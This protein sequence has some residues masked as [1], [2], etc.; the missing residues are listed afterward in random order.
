MSVC[1][2]VG[3]R[4]GQSYVSGDDYLKAQYD[5]EYKHT[6]RNFGIL[7]YFIIGFIVLKAIEADALVGELGAG[8]SVEQRKK[9]SIGVELVAKPDLLLFLDEPTSGLD[10]QSSWAIVQLLKKLANAGQSI[11]CTIHQPSATLFEQFDRL[12]LLKKGGQTVYFGDIGDNSSMVLDYFQR[13]GGRECDGSE[14]P[15]EYV[16][17]C[18]GAGATASVSENWHEIWKRSSEHEAV[19]STIQRLIQSSGSS[20][21]L[22]GDS[23]IEKYATDY[24]YQFKYVYLRT[25]VTFWRDLDYIMSKMMLL[26]VSGLYVGFSFYDVGNSYRGLQNALFATFISIIVCAPAINQIQA[27]A[28]ASRELFEVRESKSNMYHWSLPLLT[29]YLCEI[30]YHFVFSTFYFVSFYFPLKIFF[31]A[32]RSAVFFLNYSIM[33]QL[34]YV[35]LGLMV[36]YISPNLAS[37]T[38]LLSMILIFMLAFCGVMQVPSLM[39]GFWT[40][41]WK[42]SPYTYFVQNLLGLVLHDKEVVCSKKLSF[43][44]NRPKLW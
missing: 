7:W 2:S 9:L 40:F 33:F 25:A 3:S 19:D 20:D 4:P 8:L 35:G 23:K 11:L 36:L 24:F 13:N 32:S 10:S 12:L 26:L 29:Q 38:I 18:I 22:K 16:L 21:D 31:Q 28:L 27:R 39:P 14:N 6:W 17:E 43:D 30:P 44:P 41:M 5:Y 37:A 42:L 1:A 34:Y 15:A